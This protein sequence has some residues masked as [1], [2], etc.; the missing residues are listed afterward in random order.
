MVIQEEAT[1]LYENQL[2]FSAEALLGPVSAFFGG[3]AQ[4]GIQSYWM[5]SDELADIQGKVQALLVLY[6]VRHSH[7]LVAVLLPLKLSGATAGGRRSA[8]GAQVG[9]VVL[10]TS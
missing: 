6:L 1:K 7:L 10:G 8:L 2:W 9:L 4:Q 3:P 5:E